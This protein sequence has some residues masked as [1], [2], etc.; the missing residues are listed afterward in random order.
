[1]L[2]CIDGGTEPGIVSDKVSFPTVTGRNAAGIQ[3]IEKSYCLEASTQEEGG[4]GLL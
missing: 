1:V 2:G 4:R 3:C